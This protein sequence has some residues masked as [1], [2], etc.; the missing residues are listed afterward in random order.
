ME[1]HNGLEMALPEIPIGDVPNL[2][3]GRAYDTWR[4]LLAMASGAGDD[5][6]LSWANERIEEAAA[7]V[8]DGQ[9]YEPTAIIL[10]KVVE[11]CT[12]NG[13][14]ELDHN[15]KINIQTEILIPLTNVL[16]GINAYSI[17]SNLKK[18]LK[19][20]VD[21]VGGRNWLYPNEESLRNAAEIIGYSDGILD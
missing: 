1:D 16:P 11:L 3:K 2:G 6:W 18:V 21:R 19:F 9:D 5:E 7:E 8:R 13:K 15:K 14:L 12:S 17:A 20:K 4:P 10:A